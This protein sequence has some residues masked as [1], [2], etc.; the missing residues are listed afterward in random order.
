M[1]AKGIPLNNH[2]KDKHLLYGA[3]DKA[4]VEAA[5]L[6]IEQ[7][8]DLIHQDLDAQGTYAAHM[9]A[10]NGLKVLL[11][12][13]YI[14]GADFKIKDG[15]GYQP[16]DYLVRLGEVEQVRHFLAH[17]YKMEVTP[18]SLFLAASQSKNE[19]LKILIS[20]SHKTGLLEAALLLAVESANPSA[21]LFLL[22]EGAQVHFTRTDGMSS[23]LLAAKNGQKDVLELL[24]EKAEK[25]E[26]DLIGN[27]PL[28]LAAENGHAACCF[29]LMQAGYSPMTVNRRNT[30]PLQLGDKYQGVKKVLS[31]QAQQ[32]FK[33]IQDFLE[34]VK[35]GNQAYLE[36]AL[37]KLSLDER[38]YCGED[39]AEN[40]KFRT[41]L[42]H[43]VAQCEPDLT[44]KLFDHLI[45]KRIGFDP[46]VPDDKGETLA[47]YSIV[48]EVELPP[49]IRLDWKAK[50]HKNQ[51]PL[52][53]AAKHSK[54]DLFLQLLDRATP[55]EIE[56]TDDEGRTP[57][58]YALLGKRKKNLEALMAKKAKLYHKDYKLITPLF[59]ACQMQEMTL[60]KVLLGGVIDP[61]QPATAAYILPLHLAMHQEQPLLARTLLFSGV[62]C[63]TPTIGGK[64]PIHIAAQVG[65]LGLI[66][67][68]AAKG[69]S[70]NNADAKGFT[71]AHAAAA[72][73]KL[74]TLQTLLK[75]SEI[76]AEQ[77][78]DVDGTEEIS[79]LQA[80][81][82]GGQ[83]ET[84]DWLLQKFP[85]QGA[86]QKALSFAAMSPAATTILPHF[87]PYSISVQPEAICRAIVHA[88]GTDNVDAVKALYERGVS[89]NADILE[90]H[91]GLHL[92]AR[93]GAL[94]STQWLLQQGADGLHR[95]SIGETALEIS[96]TNDSFEQFKLIIDFV[97]PSTTYT[98]SRGES[99]LHLAAAAGK[100]GHVLV[101][102]ERNYPTELI[103]SR[104]YTPLHV[105][106]KKGHAKV[107]M[108]LLALGTD[109]EARSLDQKTALQL[110][111]AEHQETIRV[112]KQ[113]DELVATASPGS[114]LWHLAVRGE[115]LLPLEF[116]TWVDATYGINQP[117]HEGIT[118]LHLAASLGK[119]AFIV[120]LLRH[121]ADRTLADKKGTSSH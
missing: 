114:S 20:H 90:G 98:N 4:Q 36:L 116:L 11:E 42:Q 26:E 108:L 74:Q 17:P 35:R 24:L 7:T 21:T 93:S 89:I 25:K 77:R 51:T 3:L 33:E 61:N 106:A 48:H 94:L 82:L 30:S 22:R 107:A 2:Y 10:K 47:H 92:A 113:Y 63:D 119:K 81:A 44:K 97:K 68:L 109:S 59:L 101:L 91:T 29:R 100:A 73:G 31:G 6:I 103:D 110:V 9:A 102:L 13:F 50:N 18:R 37:S 15:I 88:L 64:R 54:P 60:V 104:K 46:N 62:K 19:L 49:T 5:K 111:E 96:A 45:R 70:F 69:V 27:T 95:S 99:L 39:E 34:G 65:N 66:G 23:L 43:I 83:P 105:A 78:M 32:Y 76:D 16:L 121:G 67:L 41:P 52:Q 79:L 86:N 71:P 118:P 87:D 8:P 84:V 55:E 56:L 1:K 58:F 85:H 75:V 12:F 57:L 40:G 53:L 112:I 38:I 28:H 120:H 115:H 80:A 14:K 117:D 72:S